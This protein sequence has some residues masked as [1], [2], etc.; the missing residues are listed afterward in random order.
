MSKRLLDDLD[1]KKTHVDRHNAAVLSRKLGIF[2]VPLP[3]AREPSTKNRVWNCGPS[4]FSA[5]RPTMQAAQVKSYNYY[6]NGAT[7]RSKASFSS[8]A[9]VVAKAT[10]KVRIHEGCSY[11]DLGYLSEANGG[12]LNQLD[13]LRC[14]LHRSEEHSGGG[15]DEEV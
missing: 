12:P 15:S 7:E 5:V 6:V 10:A 4:E 8:R 1:R 3:T 14:Q 11:F 13:S 2:A 9:I